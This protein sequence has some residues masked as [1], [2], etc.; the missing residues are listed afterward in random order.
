MRALRRIFVLACLG[1]VG[2]VASNGRWEG[3]LTRVTHTWIVDLGRAPIWAPPPEPSYATFEKDFKASE[4]FP[5]EGT[6]GLTITRVLKTDWMAVDVLLYLWAVTLAAGLL[7]LATRRANRDLVLHL[8]LSAGIGLSAA[9]VACGALWLSFGGWG[10]PAPALF[11]GLG[12]I[13][14]I[15]GGFVS[16]PTRGIF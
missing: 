14:G 2:L 13:A 7:Y 6:P 12:L 1:C 3:R 15:V 16:C 8:A 10:P 11:G 5:A 4:G 9:A